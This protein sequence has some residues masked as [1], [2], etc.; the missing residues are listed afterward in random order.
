MDNDDEI[1]DEDFERLIADCMGL[2]ESVA[3]KAGLFVNGREVFIH[4]MDALLKSPNIS[5]YTVKVFWLQH[6]KPTTRGTMADIAATR[7]DGPGGWERTK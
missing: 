3:R 6:S 5:N 1:T 2:C 4:F 7:T